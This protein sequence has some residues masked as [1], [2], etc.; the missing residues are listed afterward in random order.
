[1][2]E[3]E[4]CLDDSLTNIQWLGN[5][6]CDSLVP[7]LEEKKT[8]E[9]KPVKPPK[10]SRCER[11]PHSYSEIIQMAIGSK[12]TGRMTLQEIYTWIEDNFP[13]YRNRANSR[14]K[15]SIRHN[16]SLYDIFVRHRDKNSKVAYWSVKPNPDQNN[17]SLTLKPSPS[18]TAATVYSLKAESKVKKMKP[19]L[20][21]DFASTIEPV[22][23]A[24]I[25]NASVVC[26]QPVPSYGTSGKTKP[27]RKRLPLAPKLVT[28]VQQNPEVLF[29][30]KELGPQ[31]VCINPSSVEQ[32]VAKR[33]K[34][35]ATEQQ[36]SNKRKQKL[37][38]LQEFSPPVPDCC[39]SETDSG[40]EFDKMSFVQE[41]LT[42]DEKGSPFETPMKKGQS[43]GVATS[44]PCQEKHSLSPGEMLLNWK[45]R[46]PPGTGNG[47]L[48]SSLFRSPTSGSLGYSSL[49]FTPLPSNG[50]DMDTE[51]NEKDI[52][53]LGLLGCSPI[54]ENGPI[55][56]LGNDQQTDSCVKIFS[57]FSLPSI[58]D[59]LGIANV[60]WAPIS[61]S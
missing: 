38:T 41:L 49:G 45:V 20:P 61:H 34:K 9:N 25:I 59:G 28:A 37:W 2:N 13:F 58:G 17:G 30:P 42:E 10:S 5:L 39:T 53:E 46:T 4:T 40:L 31:A 50:G 55:D 19:L 27:V 18:E 22:P 57:D 52:V 32:I 16:L 56:T 3:R 48:D 54:K 29:P 12:P 15:N 11:P 24:L 36:S 51:S 21:R 60:S 43:V 8:I 23:V 7:K 6:S 35:T 44:T 26:H 14:W 33:W 1:M 47:L